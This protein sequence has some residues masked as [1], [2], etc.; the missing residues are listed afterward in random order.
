MLDAAVYEAFVAE[1]ADQGACFSLS[2]LTLAPQSLRVC[3]QALYN[4]HLV[5]LLISI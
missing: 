1:I 2:I 4:T 3:I 5:D